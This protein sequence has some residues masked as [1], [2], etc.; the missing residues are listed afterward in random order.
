MVKKEDTE[1]YDEKR[2]E[3]LGARPSKIEP[4]IKV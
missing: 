4:M 3:E 2:R 1:Q